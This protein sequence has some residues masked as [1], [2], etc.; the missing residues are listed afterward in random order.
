MWD[1]SSQSGVK[2]VLPVVGAQ[3]CPLHAVHRSEVSS[4]WLSVQAEQC[5]CHPGFQNLLIPAEK[6][7]RARQQVAQLLPFSASLE[8]TGGLSVLIQVESHAVWP[9]VS[10]LLASRFQS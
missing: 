4:Q 5:S 7:P 9:F 3:S 1:L 10:A 2:P 6:K 8:A